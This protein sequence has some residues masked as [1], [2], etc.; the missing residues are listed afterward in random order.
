MTCEGKTTSHVP[1]YLTS[2]EP[3]SRQVAEPLSHLGAQAEPEAEV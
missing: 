1:R 2:K 3:V